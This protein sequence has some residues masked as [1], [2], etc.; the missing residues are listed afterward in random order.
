VNGINEHNLDAIKNF[1]QFSS[2][3]IKN[4]LKPN[5]VFVDVGAGDGYYSLLTHHVHNNTKIIAIEPVTENFEQL[6]ANFQSKEIREFELHVKI[7]N[8]DEILENR[9]VDFIKIDA[10]GHEIAVL[11]GLKQ[12]IKNNDKML[13]LIK[14]DPGSQKK[15]GYHPKAL[16]K[17]IKKLD[18]DMFF[19][20]EYNR[21]YIRLADN[22]FLWGKLIS[23]I[24]KDYRY[25]NI[26]CIPKKISLFVTFFSHSSLLSGG[27][28]KSLFEL[29][30][31]TKAQGVLC[32][33]IFPEKGPF[34]ETLKGKAVSC[35][36][37]KY[38]WWTKPP[39]KK[40]C[41]NLYANLIGPIVSTFKTNPHLIYTSTVVIPWGAISAAFLNK[42]HI[43]HVREYGEKDHGLKFFLEFKKRAKFISFFSD[44][45]VYRSK[46]LCNEYKKY[47]DKNKNREFYN[48]IP[49][50]QSYLEDSV[51]E[52]YHLKD[53]LKLIMVGNI[54]ESKGQHQAIEALYEL[55][56]EGH[57]AELL[58]LGNYDNDKIYYNRL[59]EIIESKDLK[60]VYFKS[61]VRNPFSYIK[62]ADILLMCSR[63]EAFGRV[64]VEAMMLKK[65][66]IGSNSGGTVE[67]IKDGFNG[68]L[69]ELGNITDLKDKIKYFSKNKEQI[70]IMGENAYAFVKENFNIEKEG[71]KCWEL[72]KD[73]KDEKRP[74][75]ISA[76]KWFFA[77][78]LIGTMI[79]VRIFNKI[80][81]RT[82][83]NAGT[84]YH[85]IGMN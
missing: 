75:F 38:N 31:Q 54:I 57:K 47:I 60:N 81:K 13:M 21:K 63:C 23:D 70:P 18:Y 67:L 34:I 5:S 24:K 3:I 7:M 25:A 50:P 29:I 78:I 45:M 61:F 32:N 26:F 17:T 52:P 33:V 4:Y 53:S 42:P 85:N 36:I 56:K 41:V 22:T 19:I 2:E 80:F 73:L 20:D 14:L 84:D 68:F 59:K 10:K 74:V 65:P 66:V 51:E 12:T 9:K 37:I 72:F 30:E 46:A 15:A 39:L 83:A 43:W 64:T 62:Q 71:L 82:V 44:R 58:I 6:K 79:S 28:E 76:Y 77:M 11:L 40:L 69:Y 1:A 35:D 49:I 27:G 16:L 55:N 48:A 8:L